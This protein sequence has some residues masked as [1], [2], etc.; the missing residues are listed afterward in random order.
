MDIYNNVSSLLDL[1]EVVP[2]YALAA[3]M[4]IEKL[5]QWEQ[6]FAIG[7]SAESIFEAGDFEQGKFTKLLVDERQAVQATKRKMIL[8][9][10]SG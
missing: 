1:R 2:P 3:H 5:H 6:L 8:R 10:Y 9:G 7:E 4:C